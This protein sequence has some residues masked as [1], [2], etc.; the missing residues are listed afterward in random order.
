MREEKLKIELAFQNSEREKRTAELVVANSKL[1]VQNVEK[2]QL[3]ANLMLANIEL[4]F[5]NEEKEKRASELVIANAEL[6]LQNLEK[7]KRAAELILANIELAYQN[8]EKEKRAEELVIAN[9]ELVLQNLEKEKRAAE[10]IVA[11]I[12]LA[13]QNKEKEKRAEELLTA[14]S[15]LALQIEETQKRTAE[16]LIANK[17]LESFTFISSHDLQEP[18]RKIQTFSSRILIEEYDELSDTVKNYFARMQSAALHMQNL[19]NDLLAYSRTAAS[20]RKLEKC[21]LSELIQ[22]VKIIF[23]DE[24]SQ[25]NGTIELIG[26]FQIP[27]IKVQFRQL[28]QNL[29]GNA[30]KFSDPAR[31]PHI[32]INC[33][34]QKSGQSIEKLHSTAKYY[35]VTV[36]D[37]GIGFESKYRKRIFE[38]FQRLDNK[39]QVHGTGMGLTIVKKIIENHHGYISAS[40]RVNR[41]A[42]FDIYIPSK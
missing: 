7:E 5:Q 20:E 42:K 16:L 27:V 18:L 23:E 4:A 35:H 14:N 10:L 33:E 38:I 24:I 1:L 17:E 19:I 8:A 37:N 32:R 21:S 3:A 13:Y 22:E 31:A 26:D 41:G 40:G 28:L 36:Q 25:K 2:A 11:N 39:K 9:A 6:L 30:L 12:E 15:Q 29:I 34:L